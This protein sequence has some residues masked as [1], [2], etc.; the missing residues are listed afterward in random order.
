MTW[1]LVYL[2][3]SAVV[4]HDTFSFSWADTSTLNIA[5]M[6]TISAYTSTFVTQLSELIVI[7][8]WSSATFCSPKF[9]SSAP[10]E[11][12][13]VGPVIV[14]GGGGTK[15]GISYADEDRSEER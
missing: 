14:G 6:V 9:R 15:W 12:S 3:F 8:P 1:R 5:E 10:V 11:Q 2:L 7:P 4:F 13:Q